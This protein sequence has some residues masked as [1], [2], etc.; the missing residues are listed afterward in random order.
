MTLHQHFGHPSEY[1]TRAMGLK[2]GLSMKGLMKQSEGYSTGKM[3]Q[4]SISKERVPRAKEVGERI[5][6]DISSINKHERAG[7]AKFW[8]LF[9]NVHSKFLISRFLKQKLDLANAGSILIKGL[10]DQKRMK[11]KIIRCDNA[12]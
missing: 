9:M 3:R 12:G 10:E 2:L 5:L 8:A 7:G 1:I 11:I 4:K 6:M